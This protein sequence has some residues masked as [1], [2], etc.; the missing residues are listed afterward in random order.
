MKGGDRFDT[1]TGVAS[2]L[3]DHAVIIIPPGLKGWTK[4]S[5]GHDC[6]TNDGETELPPISGVA[7]PLLTRGR[8]VKVADA[9]EVLPGS[10]DWTVLRSLVIG[11]H[12]SRLSPRSPVGRV[13]VNGGVSDE[14]RVVGKVESTCTPLTFRLMGPKKHLDDS[15]Q[16]GR[17]PNGEVLPVAFVRDTGD[18]REVA[19][20]GIEKP[21]LNVPLADASRRF[22]KRFIP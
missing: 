11:K 17:N 10:P 3:L 22:F 21:V 13:R 14:M 6:T 16:I 18:G 15:A 5:V 12:V 19:I 20:V 7:E 1:P 8:R 9:D 4:G 2:V